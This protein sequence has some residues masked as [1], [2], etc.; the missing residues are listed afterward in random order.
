M[1]EIYS[2]VKNIVIF[3]VLTTIV[4]NLLGKSS[5]K[6]YINLVTGIILVI[7]VISPLLKLFQLDSTLDYYFTTNTL[8]ADAEGIKVRLEGKENQQLEA[9]LGEYKEQIKVQVTR[10]LEQEKVYPGEIK[11]VIEEDETS[12]NFGNLAALEINA[13]INYKEQE[14]EMKG[15]EVIKV[16][17]VKIDKI[18]ISKQQKEDREINRNYLS[19]ME[20]NTK[21]L[22]S[23]FYNINPDN[24]NISIQE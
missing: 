10:L 21:N 14:V 19:P 17:S 7:L 16:D 3:L 24:I 22:L 6:K 12:E 1:N 4:T 11:V 23:D 5:Y 9:I 18:K 20:I 8:L 2:W 13:S 15:Q